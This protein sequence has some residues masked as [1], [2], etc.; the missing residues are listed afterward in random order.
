M[1]I[2]KYHD[3]PMAL[4]PAIGEVVDARRSTADGWTRAIVVKMSRDRDGDLKFTVYWMADDPKA[5]DGSKPIRAFS[6]G[7]IRAAKGAW[8]PLIRQISRDQAQ[9]PTG[10]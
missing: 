10:Q 4:T 9:R 1:I 7:Y 2:R 8:P 3:L 6:T 5:G